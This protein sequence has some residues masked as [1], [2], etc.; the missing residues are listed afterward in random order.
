M[1]EY[2]CMNIYSIVDAFT[3]H[4]F[5]DDKLGELCMLLSAIRNII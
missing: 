2:M 5:A 3:K 4:V 1:Y